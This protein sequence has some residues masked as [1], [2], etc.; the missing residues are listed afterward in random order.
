MHGVSF[1]DKT[2]YTIDS[3][4]AIVIYSVYGVS[5]VTLVILAKFLKVSS[6]IVYGVYFPLTIILVIYIANTSNYYNHEYRSDINL[7]ALFYSTIALN[8][9]ISGFLI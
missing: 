6:Y 3:P 4:L 1:A 2:V 8:V 7:F 5:I 9:F